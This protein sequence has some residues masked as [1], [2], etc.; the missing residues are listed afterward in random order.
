MLIRILRN[1]LVPWLCLLSFQIMAQDNLKFWIEKNTNGFSSARR[2]DLNALY[3]RNQY[4][5][6]W[7]GSNFLATQQLPE[8]LRELA[9]AHGL[10]PEWYFGVQY[11]QAIN[12]CQ[13][14]ANWTNCEIVISDSVLRL[15][16]HIYRGRVVPSRVD[17]SIKF[18]A[19]VFQGFLELASA[20]KSDLSVLTNYLNGL[21]PQNDYYRSLQQALQILRAS[22]NSQSWL[23]IA[24]PGRVLK[25]GVR[26]PVIYRMKL[27][28]SALGYTI[29]NLDDYFDAEFEAV[30]N[31]I[32]S[33]NMIGS[34]QL[35]VSSG[36]RVKKPDG[37]IGANSQLYRIYFG[38]SLEQRI[39]E[40]Q[41][42][43]EKLRWLP[44]QLEPS[45]IFVNLANQNLRWVDESVPGRTRL[46][47]RSIVGQVGR[48]TPSMKDK[49]FRVVLN[50]DWTV[51][52]TVFMKD[53]LPLMQT[54]QARG[55]FALRQYFDENNYYLQDIDSGLEIA[56]DRINWYR[57]DP[58]E[59]SF[60]LKQRPNYSNA[61]GVVKF[62]MTNPFNI[63]LHDTGSRHLFAGVDRMLS[64]GCVRLEQPLELAAEILFGTDWSR[65][66]IQSVVQ[67]PG[68][69]GAK[70]SFVPLKKSIPIYL[71]S[72]T[73]SFSSDRILRFHHDYYGQNA[74]L[75]AAVSALGAE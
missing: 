69:L 12:E 51:P 42:S 52:P 64:S 3:S 4:Q 63:Y 54:L 67:G 20:L 2:T 70:P 41:L 25:Q 66:R 62:D 57:L 48:Q 16:K 38:R 26:H 17:S 19:R 59:L 75:Q 36:M 5:A 47:F 34:T 18:E 37:S 73:A 7:F 68:Q 58:S 33:S 1:M 65:D 49:I 40:I 22:A 53:K 13:A 23:P 39:Q 14:L 30:V 15:A 9:S 71:L 56:P 6:F 61:L 10:N 74:R 72:L 11:Q 28:A 35:D 43:M 45:H 46:Q 8:K 32:Q 60:Y 24:S 31:D 50:P 55:S 44:N 27:R 29:S 21:A